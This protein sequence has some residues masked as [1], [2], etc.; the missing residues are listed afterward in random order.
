VLLVPAE[1]M[2][3]DWVTMY[4]ERVPEVR[5]LAVQ[6]LEVIPASAIVEEH[7]EVLFELLERHALVERMQPVFQTHPQAA[8]IRLITL[9]DQGRLAPASA[10]LA[11]VPADHRGSVLDH[12][13]K[14]VQQRGSSYA[15]FG[16]CRAWLADLCARRATG[17]AEV[18]PVLEECEHR[19]RR[20]SRAFPVSEPTAQAR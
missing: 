2:K 5:E 17:W 16:L 8:M 12:I 9:L 7:F 6:Y 15:A 3:V 10:W 19:H 18:Y 13:R 4:L 20:L 11:A 1:C 14:Q